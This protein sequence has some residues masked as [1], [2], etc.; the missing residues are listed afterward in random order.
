[1]KDAVVTRDPVKLQD[2]FKKINKKGSRA[3]AC[4]Y[5]GKTVERSRK[6]MAKQQMMWSTGISLRPPVVG[7]LKYPITGYALGTK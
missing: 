7:K 4:K 2:A 6:I 3:F 5:K 1:M